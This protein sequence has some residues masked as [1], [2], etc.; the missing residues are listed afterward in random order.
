[1]P[2]KKDKG[3]QKAT[4]AQPNQTPEGTASPEATQELSE[5]PDTP[6]APVSEDEANRLRAVME[7]NSTHPPQGEALPPEP[8]MG[9][10]VG[11]VLPNGEIRPA[12]IVRVHRQLK[13]V[14]AGLPLLEGQVNLQVFTDGSNDQSS[15]F[16]SAFNEKVATGVLYAEAARYSP[17][18]QAGT[19]HWLE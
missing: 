17:E 15:A 8:R 2:A 10:T 12:V 16:G 6:T 1:M 11:Y 7:A 9:L 18:Y 19:W 3:A 13:G 5:Q 14:H 4:E